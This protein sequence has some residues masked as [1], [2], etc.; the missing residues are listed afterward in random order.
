MEALLASVPDQ[1]PIMQ[2]QAP[3]DELIELFAAFDLTAT[4][5][6]EQRG[7]TAR[8]DAQPGL[9]KTPTAQGGG[10]GSPS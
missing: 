2:Q 9:T 1:R 3:P 10:R 6:K 5:D 4:Y 7:T 8:S